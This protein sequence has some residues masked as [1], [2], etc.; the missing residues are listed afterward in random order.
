V[1]GVLELL[2]FADEEVN[3]MLKVGKLRRCRA[4]VFEE[5]SSFESSRGIYCGLSLES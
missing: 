4:R 5:M 1:V 2:V 3:E